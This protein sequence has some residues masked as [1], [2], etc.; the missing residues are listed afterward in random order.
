MWKE[1]KEFENYEVST[2]G[3]VRNKK[4]GHV[5]KPGLNKRG[6]L[7]VC[8][9]N[10]GKQISKKN[11]RLV[12]EAFIPNPENKPEVNHINEIKTD[13]HVENLNWMT[14]K[15]NMNWGTRTERTRRPVYAIYL[16]GTDEYYTSICIAARELGLYSSNI[17]EVLKG[18]RKTAGGLRFEYAE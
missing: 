10:N 7:Q 18:R 9:R 6:Y 4:T 12:A 16:D 2:E 17:V 13:N 8:L 1:I 11:H 15:E 3:E 14:S 5:L